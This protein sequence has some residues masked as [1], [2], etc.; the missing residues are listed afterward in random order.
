[1]KNQLTIRY[2]F[3]NLLIHLSINAMNLNSEVKL[4]QFKFED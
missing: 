3:K 2:L 4:F 1:M